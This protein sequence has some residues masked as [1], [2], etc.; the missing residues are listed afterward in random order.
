M[1]FHYLIASKLQS[2]YTA[3]SSCVVIRN[4]SSFVLVF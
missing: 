1:A 2:E 4:A 3:V